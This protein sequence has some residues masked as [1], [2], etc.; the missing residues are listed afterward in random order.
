MGNPE[1]THRPVVEDYE[2][3]ILWELIHHRRFQGVLV[4]FTFHGFAQGEIIAGIRPS[5]PE[6]KP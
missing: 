5:Q 4:T 1:R 2:R 6:R 3:K